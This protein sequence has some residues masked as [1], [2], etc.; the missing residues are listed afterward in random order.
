[1]SEIQHWSEAV[2]FGMLGHRRGEAEAAETLREVWGAAVPAPPGVSAHQRAAAAGRA[3]LP[4]IL[5]PALPGC[6][7]LLVFHLGGG[8]GKE[9]DAQGMQFQRGQ[10]DGEGQRGG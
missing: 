6:Q 7:C 8:K 5:R 10:K 1:M 9:Q 2:F 4:P 3:A